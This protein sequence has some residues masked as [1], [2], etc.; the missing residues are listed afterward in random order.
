MF[1]GT[2]AAD[3]AVGDDAH[4]LVVPLGVEEVD[5]ILEHTRRGVVVLRGHEHEPVEAADGRCPVLGV[6]VLVLPHHRRQG[7]VQVWERV[8]DKVDELEL[9]IRPVPSLVHHPAG[10]LLASPARAGASED[11]SDAGH[12]SSSCQG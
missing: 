4:R 5:G 1:G 10:D 12:V 8:V 9:G 6:R 11:H 2:G 3:S 7:L